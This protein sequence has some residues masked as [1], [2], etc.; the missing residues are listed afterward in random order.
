MELNDSSRAAGSSHRAIPRS[1]FPGSLGKLLPLP[2]PQLPTPLTPPPP[3]RGAFFLAASETSCPAPLPKPHPA[4]A[5]RANKPTL[6]NLPTLLPNLPT[7]SRG[8]PLPQCLSQQSF[9]SSR[10]LSSPS[11]LVA[12]T[13]CRLCRFRRRCRFHHC[14]HRG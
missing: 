3:P 14:P 6:P 4:S 9:S 12:S 8:L 13:C 1:V 10:G 11:R 2:A 7:L 5:R